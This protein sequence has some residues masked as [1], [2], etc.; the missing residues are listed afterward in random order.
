M[1]LRCE[2]DLRPSHRC[3]FFSKSFLKAKYIERV[4]VRDLIS[5]G[6]NHPLML[7]SM[8]RPEQGNREGRGKEG[9]AVKWNYFAYIAYAP[10]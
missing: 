8:D 9:R 10:T 7:G 6:R 5:F 1:N 3:V 2:R 4:H